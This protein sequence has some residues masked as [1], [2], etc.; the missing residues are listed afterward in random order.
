MS[1]TVFVVTIA[2]CLLTPQRAVA[3]EPVPRGMQLSVLPALNYD[4]DEGFGYG[5]TGGIYQ[6]GAGDRSP[7]VWSFEPIVFFTTEGRRAVSAIFD[8]PFVFGGVGRLTI[9]S[10]FEQDCCL[11][12]Y[13]LGNATA[14]DPALA[15]ADPGPNFYSYNR[16]RW[17]LVADFQWRVRPHL[18]ML[19]GFAAHHNTG[20]SRDPN[21]LFGA[22]AGSGAIPASDLSAVS[23]GPKIGFVIDTRDHERDPHRGV[24]VDGLIWQAATALGSDHNFTRLTG[25]VRGYVPLGTRL[26]AAARILGE[27]VAGSMPVTILTDMGSSFQDFAGVGGSKSVRGVFRNRFLG[28]TRFLLNL[29]LRWRGRTFSAVGQRWRPGVVGFVDAG[30]VWDSAGASG[31][32]PGLNWGRGGGLR[33]TWGDSFIIRADVAHG[34]EA[35]VQTYLALGHLF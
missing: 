13:G 1:P 11:P 35:G 23:L 2:A 31:S 5:V 6:Y 4:S 28:E 30:R 10:A 3:Q 29:E 9:F 18:R 16:K 20:T 24:W 33:L 15:S 21:T 19:T 7:Y 22:E 32:D 27:H 26:T 25:T 17:S 12:Y 8:A 14:R 34:S